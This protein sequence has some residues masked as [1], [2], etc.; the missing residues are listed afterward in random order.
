MSCCPQSYSRSCACCCGEC[1]GPTGAVFWSCNALL[2]VD[3]ANIDLVVMAVC[4]IAVYLI[5]II[6]DEPCVNVT[7]HFLP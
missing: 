6:A 1:C 4:S 2:V 7:F 5:F 3:A